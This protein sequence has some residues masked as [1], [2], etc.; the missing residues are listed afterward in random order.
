MFLETILDDAV[1]VDETTR[2]PGSALAGRWRNRLAS[3]IELAVDEHHHIR[4][5]FHTEVGM[6]DQAASYE[7]VGFV[8]G[9]AFSFCVDFGRRGSV[10]SWTGHHITND[11]RGERLVTLWHL[12][13]PVEHPH[14]EADTWRALMAGGD[15]FTRA[16]N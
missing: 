16:D 6:V 14:S 5:T 10:A 15:E 4:G 1:H 9:D 8:E 2:R 12:A 3:T 11:D 13:R 7:V